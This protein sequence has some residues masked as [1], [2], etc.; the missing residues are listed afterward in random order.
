MKHVHYTDVP[1]EEVEEGARGVKIRWLISEGDGARR[2]VMRHFEI[3]PDGYTPLHGHPWEHEVFILSGRGV[4]ACAEGEKP[5]KPGDVIFMPAL[6]THQFR[7]TDTRPVEM[8]CLIPAR[9][10]HAD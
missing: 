2:F 6:E 5:F 7:N 1:A 8:L 10:G 3:A 9:E 4:V